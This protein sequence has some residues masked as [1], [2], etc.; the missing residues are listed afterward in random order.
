[1]LISSLLGLVQFRAQTAIPVDHAPVLSHGCLQDR[2]KPVNIVYDTS[3]A[4]PKLMERI[5]SIPTTRRKR[6]I[7]ELRAETSYV[8]VAN[9]LRNEILAGSLPLGSWLRMAALAKRFGVSVQPV[10]E[11]LQQLEGEG[12][13]E[14]IPHHGARV[15]ELDPMR[16]THAHEIG[17]ALESFFARQFA[18]E[19]SLSALRKV[20]ALQVEHDAAIAELDWQRIDTANYAFHR[21]INTF[22][23]NVE[24]ADLVG[25]YYGLTDSL[26]NRFGRDEAFAR[27]VQEEH[28][29]LLD[30]F[31]RREPEAA[32]RISSQHVRGTRAMVLL[33]YE[34]LR[35]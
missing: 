31:R 33:A 32:S 19:A 12:L 22:G 13:V 4:C 9:L 5:I 30:A 28:H 18:E 10:R 8:R 34:S 1:M 23:G 11:A 7:P 17:E 20:E 3:R 25:R 15:R 6:S 24:A 29:A 2:I 16:V 35:F 27:R 14:I 21:F 26:M